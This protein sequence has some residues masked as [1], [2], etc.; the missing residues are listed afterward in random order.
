MTKDERQR[1]LAE[2]VK[3]QKQKEMREH[4]LLQEKKVSEAFIEAFGDNLPIELLDPNETKRIIEDLCET[5]PIAFWSRIDWDDSSVHQ[6][7]IIEK[8]LSRI[9]FL[10]QENGFNPCSPIYIFWG[11]GDYPSVKTTLTTELLNKFTEIIW[12]GEDMY[13]YC[14]VQKYVIEFFHNDSI[15]IGWLKNRNE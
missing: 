5:F 8:D 4:A 3:I 2:L 10:L 9:P 11:Y 15:N 12:L 1:R 7:K 14:P 6:L 13:Y